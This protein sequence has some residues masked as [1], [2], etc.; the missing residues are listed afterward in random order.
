MG[1]CFSKWEN[2]IEYCGIGWF[3]LPIDVRRLLID[4]MDFEAKARFSQCSIE[5]YEEVSESRNFIRS[6]EICDGREGNNR[7]IKIFDDFPYDQTNIRHL[8]HLNLNTLIL[9]KNK[10][11][12][13]D[14]V[15]SDFVDLSTM[16]RVE[17]LIEIPRFPFCCLLKLKARNRR[18][19][20]PSFNINSFKDFLHDLLIAENYYG[21]FS[22]IVLNLKGGIGREIHGSDVFPEIIKE[23]TMS[24]LMEIRN[25]A[26][27]G[28]IMKG[29][30][31][32]SKRL[33]NG[34]HFIVLNGY[35]FDYNH[36]RIEK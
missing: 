16:R 34:I 2:E 3:D 8:K 22:K 36:M 19:T 7:I 24:E 32:E 18:I 13:I 26:L 27:G 6:I 25:T 29:Y 28:K 5:C 20:H 21:G 10:H 12:E 17:H 35:S 15:Y 9:Q 4:S 14:P 31:R 11:D 1:T 30:M 33:E 23:Y